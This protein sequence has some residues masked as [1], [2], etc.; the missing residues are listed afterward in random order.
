MA[1]VK[2]AFQLATQF[3]YLVGPG[4]GCAN[5]PP[6]HTDIACMDTC[7]PTGELPKY[8]VQKAGDYLNRRI[9]ATHSYRNPLLE[10]R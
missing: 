6:Y 3:V 1:N 8:P 2:T 9:S 7:L 10:G 4:V 5:Y